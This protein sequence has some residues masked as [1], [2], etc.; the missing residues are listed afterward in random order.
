MGEY[1]SIISG[2]FLAFLMIIIIQKFMDVFLAERSNNIIKYVGWTIYFTF[3][4]SSNL[5]DMIKPWVL[6]SFNI[7]FIFSQQTNISSIL[8]TLDVLKLLK[9][10]FS[11]DLQYINIRVKVFTLEVSNIVKSRFINLLQL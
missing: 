7:F 2:V 3:L 5:T 8:V 11:K 4:A 6:L 9:S 1:I 10:I